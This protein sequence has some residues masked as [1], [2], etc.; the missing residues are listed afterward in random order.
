MNRAELDEYSHILAMHIGDRIGT[1]INTD[2]D[3][4]TLLLIGGV[5]VTAVKSMDK[6]NHGKAL[7]SIRGLLDSY[8]IWIDDPEYNTPWEEEE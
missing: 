4:E 1:E 7:D 6:E 2:D 3:D 8:D 5:L